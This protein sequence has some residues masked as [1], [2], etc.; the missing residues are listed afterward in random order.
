M[1]ARLLAVLAVALAALPAASAPATDWTK[2][3]ARTAQGGVRV[4]NPRARVVL[5]EIANYTC[6]H[7]AHF[8]QAGAATLTRQVRSGQ[9]SVE[10]RPIVTDQFGLAATVVARCTGGGFLAANDAL[11]R[12]QAEWVRR[13]SAYAADNDGELSRYTE[14]DR[15][16]QIALNGGIAAAAG[17]SPKQVAACFA[18]RGQLDDTLRAVQVAGAMT[19][20]TPTF[21]FGRQKLTGVV[22]AD[23][24]AKLSA[25]GL[26]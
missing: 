1:I 3:A 10:Y 2:V 6:P 26:K 22:W 20:S 17:A 23:I 18:T 4:G 7:C 16:Q 13:A 12:Q 21:L 9:L 14:L 25:A 11:Y 8:N 19:D 15:L 24:A 5:V